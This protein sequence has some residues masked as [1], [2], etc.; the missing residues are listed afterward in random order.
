MEEK[1]YT[2][3][4]IVEAGEKGDLESSV[5]SNLKYGYKIS[6]SMVIR[7]LKNGEQ[8]FMYC[9]PMTRTTKV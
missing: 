9:Q 4:E 2:T 6:G 8:G 5:N 3:Y 7:P 1:L